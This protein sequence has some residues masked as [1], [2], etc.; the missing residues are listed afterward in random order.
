MQIDKDLPTVPFAPQMASNG[1][2]W[3]ILKPKPENPILM[4]HITSRNLITRTIIAGSVINKKL[5]SVSEHLLLVPFL[6]FYKHR[7][8]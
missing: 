1:Q 7:T 5:E 8:E 2:N 3:A 4:F 6:F